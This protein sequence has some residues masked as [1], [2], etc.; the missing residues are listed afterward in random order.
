VKS[1][2]DSSAWIEYFTGGPNGHHF[3][4]VIEKPQSLLVPAMC[5]YEVF[6]FYL[7]KNKKEEGLEK[8]SSM[9]KAPIIEIS[10]DIAAF[11][12]ILS[13]EKQ[14][15]M[16]DSLILS[17]ARQHRATLWTQDQD[18][19]DMDMVRYFKKVEKLRT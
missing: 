11:A 13:A 1:V 18:F 8:I 10:A 17:C 4:A 15:A 9:R 12:A 7:G 2:A 6:R 14:L 3:A 19:K 16:A 5:L